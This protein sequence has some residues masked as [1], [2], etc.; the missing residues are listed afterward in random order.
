MMQTAFARQGVERALPW[1]T[2]GFSLNRPESMRIL[3]APDGL[4]TW[5]NAGAE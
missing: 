2:Y 1:S 5:W 4:I 3:V